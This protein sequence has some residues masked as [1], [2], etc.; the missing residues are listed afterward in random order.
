MKNYVF[1]ILAS[2]SVAASGCVGYQSKSSLTNPTAAGVSALMGNWASASATVIPSAA[3]CTDFKWTVSEQTTSSA[4]GSFSASCAGDLK[5][6]GTAQGTLSG[7]VI[8]W[9]ATGNATAPGLP[10][11][12]F[13]L[14][15]TAELGT[16]SIR[17]P[18]SGDTCL[19]KVSGVEI[20]NK[21]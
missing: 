10:A 4:K 18:Y 19:G 6:A 3:S 8:S 16:N 11:C 1:A 21:T 20:L 12:G 13:T 5:L 15:G 7:S 17:V 9:S 14:T 2:I